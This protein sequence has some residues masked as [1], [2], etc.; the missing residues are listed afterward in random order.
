M[1]ERIWDTAQIQGVLNSE[2]G[3]KA[4]ARPSTRQN[5]FFWELI[6]AFMLVAFGAVFET[7]HFFNNAWLVHTNGSYVYQRGLGDDCVKNERFAEGIKCTEWSDTKNT[8]VINGQNLTASDI[9]SPSVVFINLL[10]MFLVLVDSSEPFIKTMKSILCFEKL[11]FLCFSPRRAKN[12]LQCS[13]GNAFYYFLLSN[14]LL[15]FGSVAHIDNW[16]D[17]YIDLRDNEIPIARFLRPAS[18]AHNLAE[19]RPSFLN[20]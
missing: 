2:I 16:I 6:I 17:V 5:R 12:V 20:L 14:V 10:I 18:D 11:V 8:F 19:R 4:M 15:W 3:S 1:Q 9:E 7:F 13:L